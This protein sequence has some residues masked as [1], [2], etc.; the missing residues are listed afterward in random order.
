MEEEEEEEDLGRLAIAE[1]PLQDIEEV[2][3]EAVMVVMVIKI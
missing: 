1:E 2:P 3:E